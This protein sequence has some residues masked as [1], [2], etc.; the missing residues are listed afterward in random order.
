MEARARIEE[1][2]DGR[3]YVVIKCPGC[4]IPHRCNVSVHTFDG[5]LERPTISPSLLQEFGTGE[6]CHSFV[7]AGRIQFLDDCTF[8]NKRGFHDLPPIEDSSA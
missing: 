4:G 3:K 1:T 2:T 6:R 8:H 5:N 7:A